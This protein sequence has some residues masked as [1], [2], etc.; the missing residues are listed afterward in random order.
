M[1]P[2][3]NGVFD[4]ERVAQIAKGPGQGARNPQSLIDP[5]Q[6]ALRVFSLALGGG[7]RS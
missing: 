4:Q 6:P 3:A 7:D 2:A 5:T 1:I